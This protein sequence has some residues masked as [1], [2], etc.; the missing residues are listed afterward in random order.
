MSQLIKL[1]DDHGTKLLGVIVGV[2]DIIGLALTIEGLIP[3]AWLKWFM[4]ANAVLGYFVVRRGFT[5]TAK[6]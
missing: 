3:L 1:W 6:Q 2:K 4:F 5:N